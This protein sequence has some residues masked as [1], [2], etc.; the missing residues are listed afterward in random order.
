MIKFTLYHVLQ[1]VSK[2]GSEICNERPKGVDPVNLKL[3][4]V[5]Y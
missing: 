4:I 2:T 1:I 3:K 5:K